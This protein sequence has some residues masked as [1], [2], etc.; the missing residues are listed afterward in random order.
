MLVSDTNKNVLNF[1][2]IFMP[3]IEQK[4]NNIKFVVNT[5]P[6]KNSTSSFNMYNNGQSLYN[7][8]YTPMAG[9]EY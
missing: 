2:N 8:T 9:F 5:L 6:Y 7:V 3:N 1:E 4:S